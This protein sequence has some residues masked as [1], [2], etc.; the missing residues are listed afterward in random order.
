MSPT[1]AAHHLFEQLVEAVMEYRIKR[2]KNQILC[3]ET[4][5]IVFLVETI[6]VF[7]FEII[8][9]ISFV[10]DAIPDR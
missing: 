2:N 10:A 6:F 8:F 7:V 4:F 3:V 1:I 9:T 5:Q